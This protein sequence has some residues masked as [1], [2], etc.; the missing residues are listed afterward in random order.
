M[1]FSGPRD[2]GTEA[3]DLIARGE[4]GVLVLRAMR[5]SSGEMPAMDW[6]NSLE[7]KGIGQVQA[8]VSILE[9]S[10]LSGRPP[11]GRSCMLPRSRNQ[12]MEVRVT[13]SGAGRGPHLRLFAVRRRMRLYAAFGITKTS[14]KLKPADIEAAER[15]ADNWVDKENV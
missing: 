8:V 15:N 13:A 10:F 5:L 2:T 4:Q 6:Y 14:N 11:A 9:T 1:R 3:D 12:L 7:K